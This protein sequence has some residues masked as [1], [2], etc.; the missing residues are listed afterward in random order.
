ME[1]R[2]LVQ[3]YDTQTSLPG[4][5]PPGGFIRTA[6]RKTERGSPGAGKVA[7][8]VAADNHKVLFSAMRG[9]LMKNQHR[10]EKEVFVKQP[11]AGEASE[12]S[13]LSSTGC[14]VRCTLVRDCSGCCAGEE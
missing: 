12:K 11:L 8:K 10:V 1:I 14:A 9:G 13:T 4:R 6:G 3:K 2:Q 5:L 7:E